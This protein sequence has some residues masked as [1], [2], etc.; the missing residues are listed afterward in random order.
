M[1]EVVELKCRLPVIVTSP[2]LPK[3][4]K[5]IDRNGSCIAWWMDEESHSWLVA[6]VETGE[7]VWVPMHEILLKHNWSDGRRYP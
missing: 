5:A 6:M 2:T 4:V 7:L 3:G 1:T